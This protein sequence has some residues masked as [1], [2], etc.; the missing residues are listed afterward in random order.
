V[1]EKNRSSMGIMNIFE[2]A[3]LVRGQAVVKSSPGNGTSWEIFF[4]IIQKNNLKS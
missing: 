1:E 2:R 3:K 4:P